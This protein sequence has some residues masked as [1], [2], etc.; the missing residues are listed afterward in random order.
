MSFVIV[1]FVWVVLAGT[2]AYLWHKRWRRTAGVIAVVIALI[3]VFGSPIRMTTPS[4]QYQET[5]GAQ[6]R[7]REI[8]PR[9]DVERFNF[10]ESL[11]QRDEH[12]KERM[13]EIYDD[14][15]TDPSPADRM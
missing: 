9:V 10:E 11:N 12:N 8:P 6:S 5:T 7:H 2:A 14:I 13:N 3:T 1:P 15:T 4:R